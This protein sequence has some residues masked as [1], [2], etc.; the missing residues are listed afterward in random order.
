MVAMLSF[1]SAGPYM[2]DIPIHPNAMGYTRGPDLP[3]RRASIKLSV[4]IVYVIRAGKLTIRNQEFSVCLTR[5]KPLCNKN[6]RSHPSKAPAKYDGKSD[7]SKVVPRMT[8]PTNVR[9]KLSSQTGCH[10]WAN[11]RTQ[12]TKRIISAARHGFIRGDTNAKMTIQKATYAAPPE[13]SR[14]SEEIGAK[15]LSQ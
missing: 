8:R 12:V 5:R 3:S 6:K 4:D 11:S 1:S 15:N 2:P 13:R 10:S 7:Q 9:R 14:H